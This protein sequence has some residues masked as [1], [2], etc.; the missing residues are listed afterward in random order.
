MLAAALRE[1]REESGIV[2]LEDIFDIDVHPIPFLA[3]KNEPEHLHFDVRF[4]LQA[5][6][7]DFTIS[8]ESNDLRWFTLDEAPAVASDE[9]LARMVR[10]LKSSSVSRS[11]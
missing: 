6:G 4:L 7:A 2:G 11:R 5:R 10:K 1:A 9:S 3:S 8:E